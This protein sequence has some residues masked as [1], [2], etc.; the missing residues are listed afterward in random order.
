MNIEELEIVNN[1]Y[2]DSYPTKIV[3]KSNLESQTFEL[4]DGLRSYVCDG[5]EALK[6]TLN[7]KSQGYSKKDILNKITLAFEQLKEYYC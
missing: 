1:K 5:D 7:I 2:A 6:I 4:E 3:L